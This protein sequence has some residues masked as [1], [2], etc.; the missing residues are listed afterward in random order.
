MS[1]TGVTEEV[2]MVTLALAQL[3]LPPSIPDGPARTAR[4]C[5]CAKNASAE[6]HVSLAAH[7]AAASATKGSA[8][9][10]SLRPTDG[11]MGEEGD[12]EGEEE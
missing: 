11:R 9:A 12:G 1:C 5:T 8:A 10:R 6:R 3:R 7:A 4:C 2:L